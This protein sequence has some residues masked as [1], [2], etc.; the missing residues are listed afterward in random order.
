MKYRN[1][2]E[3]RQSAEYKQ[4]YARGLVEAKRDLLAARKAIAGPVGYYVLTW[5]PRALAAAIVLIVVADQ[6]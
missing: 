2:L 3:W 5:A 6:L 1:S 4:A